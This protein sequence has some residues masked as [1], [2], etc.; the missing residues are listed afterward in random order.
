VNAMKQGLTIDIIVVYSNRYQKGHEFAFVPPLTGIHLAAITPKQHDVR[1]THQRVTPVNLDTDA[2]LIALSF[3]TGFAMEAYRLAA[4]FKSRGKRVVAGGPHVA[5]NVEEALNHVD[6]VVLG[7]AESV[8]ANLLDDVETGKLQSIYRGEPHDLQHLPSPRYDLLPKNYLVRKVVQATR[9]CP[10][11]CSFCVTPTINPGFRTRDIPSIL[12]DVNHNEFR[13]WWQNK[14][15][16]F[17]D[18]NLTV[19]KVFIRNLLREMVPLKK[20]W[21]TQA[22]LDL[23]DDPE[24]LDL[25][26]SSG[27][28][29]IF[30]G[31]ES[32]ERTSLIHANKRHNQIESYQNKIKELHKR[33]IAVMAG[34]ITGFDGDTPE[35]IL[36]MA[37]LMDDIG[38]DVPFISV[39]TPFKGTQAYTDYQQRGRLLEQ[40]DW[41]FF[42][43]YNVTFLP[44]NMA[45]HELE[46]AHN[47]LWKRA[48]SLRAVLKRIIRSAF[49]LR[50][51]AFSMST[52]MNLYYGLKALRNNAPIKFSL[53]SQPTLQCMERKSS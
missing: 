18:D 38:V 41:S 52:C 47:Q 27:C 45:P 14:L 22:S 40:R 42:N 1:V 44:K 24:L 31:I 43:G 50:F 8:W 34:F 21:L 16:W 23:A 5:F 11:S 12:K 10:F 25:L 28:I 32:F 19:K 17:W 6:S 36:T 13:H 26:K 35:S 20:W 51:G 48:F 29:G 33:G 7:E 49:Y 2:E 37:K 4:E 9:G 46:E 53:K 15:V 30:F 39:L 3:S